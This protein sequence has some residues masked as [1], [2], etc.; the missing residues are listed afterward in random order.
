M[1][2]HHFHDEQEYKKERAALNIELVA[3]GAD[4]L[5]VL[6]PM[7]YVPFLL[8]TRFP[9]QPAFSGM[10]DIVSRMCARKN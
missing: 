9:A 7:G 4:L 6:P 3:D 1:R 2:V 5:R 10:C 8:K